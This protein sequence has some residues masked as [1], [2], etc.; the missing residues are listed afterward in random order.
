MIELTFYQQLQL[1]QAG[2]KNLIRNAANPQEKRRFL[3]IYLCKVLITVLFCFGFV[4]VFSLLFG[5]DNSI[6]GVVVLLFLLVFRQADLGIH[7]PHAALSLLLIFGILAAGPRLSNELSPLPALLLNFFCILALLVLGCHN[8]MMYNHFTLVLSYLLLQGYDVTGSAYRM[9]V[10]SLALGALLTAAILLYKHGKKSYRRRFS[11]LFRE[12]DL[13][14]A[15]SQWQVRFALGVSTALFAAAL[16]S[17]PR[18]MWA[19]IAAMSVLLPFHEDLRYRVRHRIPGNL[20]GCLLFL[21]LFCLLPPSLHAYIGI[22]GGIGVGFSATYGWQAVFNTFG[23]LTI[24]VGMFGLPGAILLRIGCNLF[25][26]VYALLF[27]T[28]LRLIGK[29]TR[30]KQTA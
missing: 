11:D 21:P 25:G 4:S 6:A 15:R 1:N 20:I 22:I 28:L 9:R 23:A 5:P 29:Y 26:A 2:S 13:T 18:A 16:F 3:L 8:V 30:Q 7:A 10:V 24:A 14:S 17:L 19:A 12:F 27:D